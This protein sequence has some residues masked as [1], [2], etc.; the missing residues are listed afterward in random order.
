MQNLE[1]T[2]HIPPELSKIIGMETKSFT[3]EEITK[4]PEI[5]VRYFSEA[6]TKSVEMKSIFI[7]DFFMDSYINSCYWLLPCLQYSCWPPSFRFKRI[8]PF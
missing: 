5:A 4:D 7:S 3:Q 6:I 2:V 1:F 8:E